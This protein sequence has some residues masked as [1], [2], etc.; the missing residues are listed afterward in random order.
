MSPDDEQSNEAPQNEGAE[1][2]SAETEAKVKQK[3]E[4]HADD[5]DIVQAKKKIKVVKKKPLK[6]VKKRRADAKEYSGRDIG[7]EIDRPTRDCVDVNCP[8]HGKLSV[9]G[10][11]IKGV[12]V[13]TKMNKTAV[14]QR[15]RRRFNQKYE[16]YDKRTKK[17]SAH[18]PECLEIKI[19]EP[20]A[21][22][23]CR[24]ISKTVSFVIIGRP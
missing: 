14:I 20:V 21:V 9:R 22:M 5:I 12:C 13:S 16:R 4:A 7:I 17:I 23:E 2:K 11:I 15:E 1:Q 3:K 18:N 6:P 10:Q 8:Y 19:G 24:P